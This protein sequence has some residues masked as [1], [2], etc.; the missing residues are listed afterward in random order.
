MVGCAEPEYFPGAVS[1]G[2]GALTKNL[3]RLRIPALGS[4]NLRVCMNVEYYGCAKLT[5]IIQNISHFSSPF[6]PIP[7]KTVP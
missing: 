5:Y 2:A 6:T 4:C 7:T 3:S 1:F